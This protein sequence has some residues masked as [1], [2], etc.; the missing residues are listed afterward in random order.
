MAQ[1]MD[2]IRR[3]ITNVVRERFD[4]VGIVRVEVEEGLDHDG[5]QAFFVRV[6]FDA[7]ANDLPAERLSGIK[8]H[9]RSTLEKLGEHRFP[10]TRFTPRSE[11][12]GAAA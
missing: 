2:A 6:I 10:Y 9:L 1:D 11:V 3:A 8:R 5:E 4:S 12:D 7:D